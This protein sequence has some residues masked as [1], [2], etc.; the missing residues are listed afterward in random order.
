[1]ENIEGLG[2]LFRR[3]DPVRH[4]AGNPIHVADTEDLILVTHE[5]MG[6]TLQQHPHLFVRVRMSLDDCSWFKLNI[7][8]HH[9]LASRRIDRHSRK[10]L[11][12][13][14]FRLLKEVSRHGFNLLPGVE[15]FRFP[16]SVLS[17]LN[18]TIGKGRKTGLARMPHSCGKF[19]FMKCGRSARSFC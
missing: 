17:G 3:D 14:A 13:R 7:A 18:G 4:S 12:F 2:S 19:Q 15:G 1:M 6:L 10:N 11:M 16:I 5:E 8:Q 9:L